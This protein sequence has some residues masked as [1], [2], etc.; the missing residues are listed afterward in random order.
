M[1][2]PPRTK[3]AGSVLTNVKTSASRTK[4]KVIEIQQK[5]VEVWN[6]MSVFCI[7]GA[8]ELWVLRPPIDTHYFL[9][10][11]IKPFYFKV[12]NLIIVFVWEWH[13]FRFDFKIRLLSRIL[14]RHVYCDN[15]LPCSEA[16]LG[17][18]L[19]FGILHCS[20]CSAGHESTKCPQPWTIGKNYSNCFGILIVSRFI[21]IDR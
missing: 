2:S 3:A 7:L 8:E 21:W 10:K 13:Q 19:E 18:L 9:T 17:S 1:G 20:W 6:P 16:N 4:N 14:Y 15:S 5:I 12:P 11:I